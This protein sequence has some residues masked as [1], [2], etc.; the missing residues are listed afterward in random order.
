VPDMYLLGKA[1]GGGVV[2]VSAV[3]A[4]ADV[5]GV[6]TPG[7]H[8]STFGGNPLAAAVGLE[9]VRMLEEGDM[10]ARAR[11]LGERLHAGLRELIG[12]GVTAVRGVGLWA[13]I[14]IDPAAGTARDVCLRL[15]EA[16]ILAKDTHGHT[17]RLAPPIVIDEA[18][19]DM[20]VREF[21]KAVGA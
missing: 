5:L 11:E 1:L 21:R 8:G 9:V 7:S 14:D 6:L 3:V 13:G 20:L 16:G 18:D 15:L 12:N 17:V 19:L 10:Q 2:P 4:D